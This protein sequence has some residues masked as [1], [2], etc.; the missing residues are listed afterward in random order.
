MPP[1]EYQ[2]NH[3]I[4]RARQMLVESCL[5]IGGIAGSCGFADA[6]Y[7]S[8]RFRIECGMSPGEY[9]RRFRVYR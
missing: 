7:F 2:Q 6:L 5:S 9:R 1:G 4:M 3:R 8:R